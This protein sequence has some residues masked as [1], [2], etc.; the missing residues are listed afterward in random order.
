MMVCSCISSDSYRSRSLRHTSCSILCNGSSWKEPTKI[1]DTSAPIIFHLYISGY[2]LTKNHDD[3]NNDVII[4][5]RIYALTSSI[6][7]TMYI[8]KEVSK[9][10]T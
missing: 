5:A 7:L 8:I 1:R 4:I 6:V 10:Y 9:D 2:K 3:D